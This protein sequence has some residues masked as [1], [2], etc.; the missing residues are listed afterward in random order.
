LPPDLRRRYVRE[1][2]ARLPRGCVGL[3]V[4][5]EYPPHQKQGPPFSVPESEVR[6]LFERDWTVERLVH[7]DILSYQDR[8]REEGVTALHAA[9]YRL[10]RR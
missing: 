6:E 8:F 9:A 4:T 3:L 5:L 2:Y 10:Q 7:R 1:M